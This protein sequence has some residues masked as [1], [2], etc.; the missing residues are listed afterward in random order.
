VEKKTRAVT[1]LEKALKKARKDRKAH[2]A[3]KI[4]L[5]PVEMQG[6]DRSTSH[7]DFFLLFFLPFLCHNPLD[8]GFACTDRSI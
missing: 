1:T 3:Y 4:E 7:S 6:V 8:R 2:E 5:L